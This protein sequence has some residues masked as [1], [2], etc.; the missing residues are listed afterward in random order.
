MR[1]HVR[2]LCSFALSL[3]LASLLTAS[4][5]A[6]GNVTSAEV[7]FIDSAGQPVSSDFVVMRGSNGNVLTPAM[8][9]DGSYVLSNIGRKLTLEFTPKGLKHR[10][11]DLT[12]IRAPKVYL[13][14]VVDPATGRIKE[15][16]QKPV[17]NFN[18]N[19]SK[20][21]AGSLGGTFGVVVPPS[22]NACATPI[23]VGV[24]ATAFDTTEATTDG[25]ANGCGSGS[26][27]ANDIWFLFTAP[28]TGTLTAA[29]CAATGYDTVIAIYNGATC[30]P[31]APLSCNDDGCAPRSQTNAAVVSGNQYLVRVGGFG[32]GDKG[33]GTLNLSF[34][35]P[36]AN[37]ECAGATTVACGS[38]TT[39]SNASATA[40]PADPLLSC[41]FG[42]PAQGLG[43]IWFKFVPPGTSA[44]LDT[45]LSAVSDTVMGLYS[46]TCGALTEIACDDDSGT[47]LRSLINAG[48][49]TPGNTYYVRISSFS[50]A[51]LGSITLSL[52]C[53]AGVPPG[54]LCSG[55]ITT[56]CGSTAVF[57][58]ALFTTDP[59]DPAFSCKFGGP[60]QG[61]GTAWFK[62]VATATSAKLDTNLSTAPDTLLAVYSGTCGA[63]TELGCS[64][65]EGTGL[66]SE[67][68]VSGLTI[69][70]T[71]Y[72]QVAS[73]SALDTG[74]IS[75][76]IQCPCP[77]PPANDTCLTATDL[78]SLPA[79][80]TFDNSLATDDIAVP[81]GVASGP[82]KN[83]WFKV[84]GT[85]NT[86]TATTCNAGTIVSDTK[87]SVFCGDC[88]SLTCVDGNDDD[89]ASGGPIFASTVSWCSQIGATYFIT[90]GNFSASTTSGVIKL[91]VFESGGPCVAD[92]QCLPTGSCCLPN[93]SCV[94]TTSDDC[95]A[96]SGLYGGNGTSCTSEAVADGSFEGG[97]PS[98]S[99]AEASTNFGT[100]IC[101]PGAC[102]VGGGTGPRTGTF[103][104]WFGGVP[105]LEVGSVQQ[106]LTIPVGAST[107]DFYLEIPVSSG[108]G[109]DFMRV[110]IDGTTVFSVLEGQA[111]YA[112]I[113]Y[114]LVSIPLGAFADGGVHTLR[115]ESTQTGAPGVTNFFV[116][117]ISI[118][119]V[120]V[121]CQQP[122]GACC[123]ADG[124]CVE[125][126]EEDCDAL[127]GDFGG[128]NTLCANASCPQ[129]PGACC[130][131]DGSCA[132]IT[133]ED[134]DALGGTYNG[135][136]SLC[137]NTSCCYTLDFSTEDDF[138][139]PLG[140][141]QKIDTEFGNL[142][143]I[144]GTGANNGPA[145]FDSSNPGP[146]N[147][148]QDLDLLI[149]RG[150]LLI[151]QNNA[152]T[153]P[154][155][156]GGFF[157]KPNDDEDGGNLF[158]DF[159]SP[160]SATSLV[161][162]DIDVGAGQASSV[163]LTD[164]SARTRTYTVPSNWTG[165]LI[166]NG[167]PA[168][169]TLDLTTLAPQPGYASVA[170]AAQDAGF[171]G[172]AVV[173][174][175]VHF[176]SSGAV[177]DVS[178]CQ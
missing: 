60:G 26:Q 3:S 112:G 145:I 71:Y 54:D 161:L 141:G 43:S 83:V 12:L 16:V 46:G 27:I 149:N 39:Q 97:T 136:F 142:V 131:L 37:D 108:N 119:A 93:G 44:T 64:E 20:P 8:E 75:L 61:V 147:P 168:F 99:W 50:A 153:N 14:M 165:D 57:N 56:T 92:V 123:L 156:V 65:D 45:S 158:L 134:C 35:G 70:N 72:V 117:D 127:N 21:K 126:T 130:L 104:A 84:M 81:C 128:D 107:L 178:W 98:A 148:S 124:S 58:N 171:D 67:L 114:Q 106:S 4:A 11:L 102:G 52:T 29:T 166:L 175:K 160:V 163:T 95:A 36:P 90:V 137:A 76:R 152:A 38:N 73:F 176:G 170:T 25:P 86:M 6:Q 110:K 169:L 68:C 120:T 41:F 51:S 91:D 79:S 172:D 116:D 77:A 122:T 78:L 7:R 105:A 31:G 109:V 17:Y 53:S 9:A 66:L 129:P 18:I 157:P 22:N 121:V 173:Q 167:G 125:V 47:G 74:S 69:G 118:S 162:V 154:P 155:A 159:A 85:G 100:P 55:A 94:T 23:A 42:G 82:F 133:E 96:Q 80:N 15:I 34:S 48:G 13:S 143:T 132:E 164:S 19:Q 88:G 2:R 59:L 135:D 111:P 40:N 139:T 87:I 10:S 144:T 101:D 140:N 103:W 5:S 151:L 33:T 62:F 49:L 115:F 138:V 150:N 89:C 177:D 113:G 24:G 1:H 30:P 28:G 174:I 63:F 146:N 32:S